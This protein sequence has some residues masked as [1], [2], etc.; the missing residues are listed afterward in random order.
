MHPM[1]GRD[2][3][4]GIGQTVDAI[5]AGDIRGAAAYH[6]LSAHDRRGVLRSLNEGELASLTRLIGDARSQVFSRGYQRFLALA[7]GRLRTP[8]YLIDE[9]LVEENMRVLRYVKDRTGCRI[10]HA[11]KAYA[12]FS[13]SIPR[14]L[15][16]QTGLAGVVTFRMT[17]P[18]SRVA[19]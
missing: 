1:Q 12:T 9:E 18:L 17:R 19:T 11:L 5:R 6:N 16:S 3:G 8:V 10:L 4:T 2:R 13:T 15:V 14:T 7:Q